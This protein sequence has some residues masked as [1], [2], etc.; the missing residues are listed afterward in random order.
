[1]VFGIKREVEELKA[2]EPGERF[3]SGYE[4][5]HVRNRLL[6]LVLIAVG[7][8]L[9][10][11]AAATF[12]LPGP[13]FVL[14]LAGLALVGGQAKFVARAMDRGEVT[15]RRWNERVWEPY[16]H[17]RLL[18][19]GITLLVL[20]AIALLGWL[21]DERGWLPGWLDRLVS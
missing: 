8:T 7:F 13:N 15:G 2:A 16:P 6:R 21:A 18:L 3:V 14:V 12:W 19:T 1:M 5:T 17:K 9:M 10:F 11:A 4:R 20:V